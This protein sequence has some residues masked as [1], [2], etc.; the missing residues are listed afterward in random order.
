MTDYVCPG[1]A[2]NDNAEDCWHHEAA[3]PLAQAMRDAV[4]RLHPETSA[5]GQGWE[6]GSVTGAWYFID[7]A[8]AVYEFVGPAPWDITFT[9]P[10]HGWATVGIVN[11]RHVIGVEDGEGDI[12]FG[13]I[14]DLVELGVSQP[15]GDGH[16]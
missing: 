6:P 8:E 3:W 1:C 4:E 12:P 9:H 16:D 2:A 10:G 7:D 13:Y 11:G 15:A 14:V 5:R